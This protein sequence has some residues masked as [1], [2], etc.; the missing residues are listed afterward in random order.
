MQ[1][2][3]DKVAIVTGAG[4]GIGRG[5]ALRFGKEGAKVVVASRSLETVDKVVNEITSAGGIAIGV[6]VDVGDRSQVNRMVQAAIEAFGCVDI[7]VNNAQSWGKPGQS[8]ASPSQIG[9]E[10][11]PE[12]EWD[13]TF[14]TG[15]KATLYAM[16]A[17]FPGMKQ[18]GWG[19]IINFGSPAAQR[20]IPLM[21]AYN[22]NKQAIRALSRTAAL[23]W[24]KTGITVNV[25]SPIV[26]TESI[27]SKYEKDISA[28]GKVEAERVAAAM[29]A[30]I[31]MGRMG[32]PEDAGAL[33][34]FICSDDASFI[35]G[36]TFMLDG[37]AVSL[38]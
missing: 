17:V 26:A 37:G 38:G 12:D 11:Y 35:T 24:A 19:R 4:R 1:K 6:V 5:I 36:S 14:Q 8:S 30:Q 9:V 2:L 21:A 13:Y 29:A 27:Q 22:A 18:K 25:I 34:T 31:P 16:Q 32:T 33:A 3:R 15:L 23:E 20:S 7:L 28:G 10:N